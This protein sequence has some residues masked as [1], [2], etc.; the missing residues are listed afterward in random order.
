PLALEVAASRIATLE[1]AEMLGRIE[2]RL[3]FAASRQRDLP[4]RQRT[5][6][7]TIAWSYELLIPSVQTTFH[8]V[9]VFPGG[10]RAD[11]A[12][13]V[14]DA[15]VDDLE[16]LC[17]ASLLR[18]ESGRFLMLDTVREFALELLSASGEYEEL[19]RRQAARCLAVAETPLDPA[20]RWQRVHELR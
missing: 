6:R 13:H 8:R 16:S 10:T 11:G 14:C 12:A 20:E 3:P 17:D 1:P 4:E 2:R 5:L 18:Y 19:E 15:T 7:A 9:A